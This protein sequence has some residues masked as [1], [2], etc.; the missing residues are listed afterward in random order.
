[1]GGMDHERHERKKM[2]NKRKRENQ[3]L[4]ELIRDNRG[5]EERETK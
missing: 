5:M 2:D 3:K 4:R 1:M